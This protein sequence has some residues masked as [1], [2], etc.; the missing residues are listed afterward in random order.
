MLL[1]IDIG[2]TNTVFAVY[3]GEKSL[4]HWRCQTVASRTADE[5]ASFLK[6]LFLLADIDWEK[7]DDV[8]VSSVVPDADF[9][10][11][12]FCKKYLKK[13]PIMIG[14]NNVPIKVDLHNPEEVGADRLVNALAV[15]TFY[16]SPAV[17]ID[18]GTATT[19][20][21]VDKKGRYAG[22]AIAPGINLSVEAL[23]RAAAKLPR[24]SIK[25]PPTVI[26]KNTVEAIQSGI[27]F[28]YLGL[29]ERIVAG[30][31]K[32]LGEKKPFVLA[33]G[34]LA[35]LFQPHTKIIQKIDDELTLKGLLLVYRHLKKQK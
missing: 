8:I 19:F 26:G 12:N 7:L 22:G 34:G 30:I 29:V 20:D 5:Y 11:V 6:N 21:V 13:T 9:H 4:A 23:Q 28:G 10:I 18:F 25:K 14:L 15:K 35:P 2:N 1:A 33:T 3:Q 24:I 17:V 31:A 27:F 16:K 32:E